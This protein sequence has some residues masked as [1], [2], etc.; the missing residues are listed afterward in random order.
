MKVVQI[1][2]TDSTI[3]PRQLNKSEEKWEYEIFQS[4]GYLIEET[5]NHLVISRD[6]CTHVEP[7]D[8]RG[9]LVVPRC[10][11]LDFEVW[12]SDEE[13]DD[14]ADTFFRT[15]VS[16]P[17][18]IKWQ[19]YQEQTAHEWDVSEAMETGRLSREHYV[20]FIN[21]VQDQTPF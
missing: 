20:A 5:D 18:W 12:F 21:Y 14:M 1:T 10:N 6:M 19:K 7:D 11:V 17:Y 9:T 3:Y 2:W 15:F 16:H 4:V 8:V 13:T